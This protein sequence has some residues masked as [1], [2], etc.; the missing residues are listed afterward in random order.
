MDSKQQ[1]M[2]PLVSFVITNY[3]LPVNLLSKCIDSVLALS[4]RPYEREIILVDDGS[5]LSPI[6]DLVAYGDEIIYVRQKHGG[7]SIARNTGIQMAR[8][9]YLQFIDG[10]DY[11]MQ[12]PYEHCLDIVRYSQDIDVVLFN[13]THSESQQEATYNDSEKMR[14]S[15]YMRNHNIQGSVCSCLFRKAARGSLMFT[16]GIQY[17]EDEEFTPQ[18]LLRADCICVTDAKAYFYRTHEASSTHQADTNS[19]L[20]R[21]DDALTVLLHLNKTADTLPTD[22]RTALQRRVAQLT[23][24]Y[25]Y[26]T[27]MLTHSSKQLDARIMELRQHGLFPLPDRDYTKK[28]QW[29]RRMIDTRLG[30]KIL[31]NSL[32]LLKRER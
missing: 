29:F 11:L 1:E 25:L 31:L 4:L 15:D 20:Q 12:A 32:P 9:R 19:K 26:N 28:Y 6:N 5:N 23:M 30:R 10:D 16:P 8:G 14:G 7:V 22:E 24:D 17:G 27:I 21:L 13:F 18:L 2:T 3:N